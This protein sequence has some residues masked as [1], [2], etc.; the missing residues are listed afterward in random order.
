MSS[1]RTPRQ[2]IRSKV[3]SQVTISYDTLESIEK[4]LRCPI[5]LDVMNN[6]VLTE[7]Q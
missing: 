3:Q 5:C 2:L 1:K 4:D 7:V 6:V